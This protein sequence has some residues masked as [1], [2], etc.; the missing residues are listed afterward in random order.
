MLKK[1]TVGD[2]FLTIIKFGLDF[3]KWK[4]IH[5]VFNSENRW[6]TRVLIIQA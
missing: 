2:N 1:N 4:A 5:V 6:N 3:L